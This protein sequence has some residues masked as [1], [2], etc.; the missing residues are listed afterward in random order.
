MKG[1]LSKKGGLNGGGWG[2]RM[3]WRSDK[4]KMG[5]KRRKIGEGRIK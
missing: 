1:R 4:R 2:E 3:G 5:V